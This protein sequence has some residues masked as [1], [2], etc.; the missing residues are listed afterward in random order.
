MEPKSTQMLEAAVTTKRGSFRRLGP[1]QSRTSS[2][3][4]VVLRD[5]GHHASRNGE[6]RKADFEG[7]C[8]ILPAFLKIERRD[9]QTSIQLQMQKDTMAFSS[10]FVFRHEKQDC[11]LNYIRHHRFAPKTRHHVALIAQGECLFSVPF[12]MCLF[13]VP[14]QYAFSFQTFRAEPVI[15]TK[16]S[17]IEHRH[18]VH[19]RTT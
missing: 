1:N 18:A 10:R 16:I 9:S 6:E 5:V 4:H 19:K 11:L 17:V 2:E 8:R 7:K 13:N 3:M 15:P 14:F 12:A